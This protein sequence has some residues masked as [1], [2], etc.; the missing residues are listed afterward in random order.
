MLKLVHFRIFFSPAGFPPGEGSGSKKKS[1]KHDPFSVTTINNSVH[2]SC[3]DTSR[4]HTL[5]LN[6]GFF[7]FPGK[8]RQQIIAIKLHFYSGLLLT[9]G[10]SP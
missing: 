4:R 10:F 5:S 7:F 3:Y 8:K 6:S 1:T 9:L 2:P